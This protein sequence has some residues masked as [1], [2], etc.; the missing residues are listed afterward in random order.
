MVKLETPFDIDEKGLPFEDPDGDGISNFLEYAFGGDPNSP[1][2]V[3]EAGTPIMPQV[4][5]VEERGLFWFEI[6]WRQVNGATTGTLASPVGGFI[7]RDI[8][9][10]PQISFNLR[11]WSDGSAID[12]FKQIGDAV[13]NEDGTVTI[14]ARY[15]RPVRQSDKDKVVVFGRVKVEKYKVIIR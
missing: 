7:M 10:I 2:L 4:R 8:K 12:T 5:M 9:Y 6:I 3:S 11:T 14:T 13:D 1:S 15:A